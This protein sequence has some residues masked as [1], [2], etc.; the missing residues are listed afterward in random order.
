MEENYITEFNSDYTICVNKLNG[1]E[2]DIIN[3]FIHSDENAVSDLLKI[4]SFAY[5]S[6]EIRKLAKLTQKDLACKLNIS[7]N[8]IYN[9]ENGKTKPS[10]KTVNLVKKELSISDHI[11]EIFNNFELKY[12]KEK[13]EIKN[14]LSK[15]KYFLDIILKKIR[16][17][18]DDPT[19][20]KIIDIVLYKKKFKI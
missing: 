12:L 2:L 17:K 4:G 7:E 8:T 9:Y 18:K 16:L 20:N 13:K 15:D 19:F 11:L 1:N 14:I 5:C 10:K 6:R 3:D